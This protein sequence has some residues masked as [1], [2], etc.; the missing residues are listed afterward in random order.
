[1][2]KKKI[3]DGTKM[4]FFMVSVEISFSVMLQIIKYGVFLYNNGFVIL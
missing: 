1:M 4:N 3:V 2:Q